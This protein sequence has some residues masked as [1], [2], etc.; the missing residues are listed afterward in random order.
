MAKNRHGTVYPYFVCIGRHQKRTTCTQQA[1]PIEWVEAKVEEHYAGLGF[2][3]KR[4]ESLRHYVAMGLSGRRANAELEARH[5]TTRIRQLTDE[6]KKLLQAH[7]QDA[8]PL[9]LLKEEQDRISRELEAAEKRLKATEQAF[10]D[11]QDT[12]EKALQFALDCQLAY[13]LAGPKLRRQFNQAFFEKIFLDD[14]GA[15][16][17][18]LAEPFAVLLGEELAA[19]AEAHLATGSPP[20]QTEAA[21]PEQDG[22]GNGP[23]QDGNPGAGL[24]LRH[25]VPGAGLEPARPCGQMILSHSCLPI[26]S[27]G[28][29]GTEPTLRACVV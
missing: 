29:A 26:P 19:E 28:Q 9:D 4:A 27:P 25:L 21:A 23:D 13:R 8:I 3:A 1:M 16:R 15:V 6:R 7:Y 14:D 17:S 22:G 12:L 5:Q 20:Q 11:I 10:V 18:E 2:T 24:K